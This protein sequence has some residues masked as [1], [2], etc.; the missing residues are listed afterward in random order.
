[1]V[2]LFILTILLHCGTHQQKQI[3]KPLK[4]CLYSCWERWRF[5]FECFS[6][7]SGIVKKTAFWKESARP[8]LMSYNGSVI[9]IDCRSWVKPAIQPTVRLL[10]PRQGKKSHHDPLRL[11]SFTLLTFDWQLRLYT[12]QQ[13]NILSCV[14]LLL[15]WSSAGRAED[16]EKLGKMLKCMALGWILQHQHFHFFWTAPS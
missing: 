14:K 13:G 9:Y 10:S 3:D 6:C 8:I 15:W 1:M 11:I 7:K 12:T 4:Q 2:L 5:L 16:G